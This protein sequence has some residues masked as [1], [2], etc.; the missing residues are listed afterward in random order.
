VAKRPPA[1]QTAL[2]PMVIV[3]VEQH[4]P[5]SQ[6]L[7]D[8][9]LASRLLPPSMRFAAWLSRWRAMR[10][11]SIKATEKRAPGIWGGVGCRKRYI[12]DKVTQ[13]LEDGVEAVVNLGAGL[14]TRAYR[15]TLPAGVRAFEVDLPSNIA[16]KLARLQ[17]VY[18]RV[19]DHVT[20]V[21]L[22]FQSQDLGE[23]LTAHGFQFDRPTMFIW[24]AVT[25]YLTEDG[26]RATLQVLAKAAPG[27]RLVFTYIRKDFLDGT[28]LYDAERLYQEFRVKYGVWHFGLNPQDVHGLLAE[29]DWAEREQFGAG[30]LTERYIRPTGRDLHVSEIERCVYAEKR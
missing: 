9:P 13:A 7:L 12:D 25:Q 30:E 18:G 1:A 21:P 19:P 20:L 15:L 10:E 24:E 17:A 22:D 26:I 28:H 14:D 2:G 8:D 27:S 5:L 11:L 29:Y 4:Y 3:A 23:T 16:D 6:R